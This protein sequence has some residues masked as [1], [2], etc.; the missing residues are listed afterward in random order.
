MEVIKKT[1][2]LTLEIEY[3]LATEGRPAVHEYLDKT[4]GKFTW[5]ST[6]SG[7]Y[8][9]S[10]GTEDRKGLFIAHVNVEHVE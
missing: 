9:C 8:R 1:N 10:K 7:P 4:Y 6:R 5:R 2:V 3:C